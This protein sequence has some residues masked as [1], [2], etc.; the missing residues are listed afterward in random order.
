M[1]WTS[2]GNEVVYVEGKDIWAKRILSVEVSSVVASK[3]GDAWTK[4][5]NSWK[6]SVSKSRWFIKPS[7]K[8]I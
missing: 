6:Y 5:I 1:Y 3:T 8:F 7:N 4:N 2:F